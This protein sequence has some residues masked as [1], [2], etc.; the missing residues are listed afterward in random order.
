MSNFPM[1][2]DTE[3]MKLE[4]LQ[5]DKKCLAQALHESLLPLNV[6]AR[7]LKRMNQLVING[8]TGSS[9]EVVEFL[10]NYR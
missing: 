4:Q 5:W 9:D 7:I 1:L 6:Q 2:K 10:M 8:E 3:K